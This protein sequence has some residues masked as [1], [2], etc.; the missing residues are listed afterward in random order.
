M[1]TLDIGGG[2]GT[3]RHTNLVTPLE[4]IQKQVESLGGRVQIL[5]DNDIIAQGLF[6]TIYPT[7][8]VCL[9]FLKSFASEGH[10]IPSEA[11]PRL[12]ILVH[13][14]PT[15]VAPKR[16]PAGRRGRELT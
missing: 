4:A 8:E 12:A 7:P 15:L 13:H 11:E 9:L 2:S 14:V 10:D 5:L 16:D 3:V 1:G 6:K